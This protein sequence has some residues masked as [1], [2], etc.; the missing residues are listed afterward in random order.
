MTLLCENDTK[1]CEVLSEM[2]ERNLTSLET[3]VTTWKYGFSTMSLDAVKEKAISE[4]KR[5][6]EEAKEREKKAKARSVVS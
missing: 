1:W 5:L 2:K 4:Q 6:E 3:P